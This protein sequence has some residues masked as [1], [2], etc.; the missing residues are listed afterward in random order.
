MMRT[1]SPYYF[2][3]SSTNELS[4]HYLLTIQKQENVT[5]VLSNV[6]VAQT[7]NITV[8]D[9]NKCRV[10]E[11]IRLYPRPPARW[12]IWLSLCHGEFGELIQRKRR[13]AYTPSNVS[14]L[15]SFTPSPPHSRTSSPFP[16][17]YPTHNINIYRCD[18]GP[19]GLN[20]VS[21]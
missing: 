17:P 1:T 8:K 14:S 6:K 20:N 16:S 13:T 9:R 10:Y 12:T 7:A 15:S 18:V 4:V 3:P 5:R 2:T 11:S 19:I 21:W